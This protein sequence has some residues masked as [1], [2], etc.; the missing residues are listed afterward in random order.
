MTQRETPIT[1][2]ITKIY[3]A[4]AKPSE[5]SCKLVKFVSQFLRVNWC[6]FVKFVSA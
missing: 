1:R 6:K 4:R 5:H 2:I 3:E